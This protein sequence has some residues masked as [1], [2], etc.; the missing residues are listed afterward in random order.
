MGYK[1][2]DPYSW[3]IVI[4]DATPTADGVMNAADKTKLDSL[5]RFNGSN[6]TAAP[7]GNTQ[8][9]RQITLTL[10]DVDANLLVLAHVSL[11][12][13]A[14]GTY[15]LMLE[16]A[17]VGFEGQNVLQSLPVDLTAGA[18]VI[19]GIQGFSTVPYPAGRQ[20]SISLVLVKPFGESPPDATINASSLVATTQPAAASP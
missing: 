7:L 11:A 5:G 2:R 4:P 18:N 6:Q 14:L 3:P 20:V 12:A 9:I 10:G 8:L 15:Q 17:I 1:I 19:L 16:A 13:A